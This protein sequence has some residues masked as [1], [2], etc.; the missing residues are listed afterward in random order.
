LVRIGL[1]GCGRITQIFHLKALLSL[2]G[3]AV[4]ALAEADAERRG[5]A[6]AMV[7]QARC[8]AD[9]RELLDSKDADAVVICLPSGMHAR[10]A[11]DSFA[12]GKHVYLE[13]PIAIFADEAEAVLRAWRTSAKTAMVG[14]NFRYNPLYVQA[15]ERIRSGT[16]GAIVCARSVFSAAGRVLPAWKRSRATGGGVLLDLASHHLDLARFLFDSE[17]ESIRATTRS[18]RNENDSATVE[19]VMESGVV[20]QSFFSMSSIEEH[21]FD[22][23]GV[24][25]RLSLDRVLS[26]QVKI[27]RPT[28]PYDRIHRIWDSFAALHPGRLMRSPG[29]PS[30]AAA[31]EAFANCV[32]TGAPTS[33]NLD[34]GYRSLM[35]VLAAEE[36]ARRGEVVLLRPLGTSA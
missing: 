30:F 26:R 8:F 34:D 11:I 32:R 24:R 22:V 28:M 14:F 13:K 3:V 2:P 25:G 12:A 15:R 35:A 33:P 16:L 10:S 6:H 18:I 17:I 7:P 5:Q 9:Y 29:E 27:T 21:R 36:S 4:T 1:V 23:Y 20:L 19:A 31:L